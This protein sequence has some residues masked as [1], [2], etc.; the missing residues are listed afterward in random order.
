VS[1]Q[2]YPLVRFA[3]DLPGSEVV[4]AG[5]SPAPADAVAEL[6]LIIFTYA[7]TRGFRRIALERSRVGLSGSRY[8]MFDDAH[9]RRWKLRISEHRRRARPNFAPAHF[10]LTSLDGRSGLAEAK[11]F[12]DE[13]AAGTRPWAEVDLK[14]KTRP[15]SEKARS[16]FPK[17]FRAGKPQP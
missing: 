6:A 8:L 1:R 16:R 4:I 14:P 17:Y 5:A 9:G 7:V 10:D 3:G 2:T 12:L 13:V 15:F 11:A